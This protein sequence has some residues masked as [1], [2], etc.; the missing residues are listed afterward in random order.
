MRVVREITLE[1]WN[2]GRRTELKLRRG[3]GFGLVPE[4]VASGEAWAQIGAHVMV[5]QP[6][7]ISAVDRHRGVQQ[8]SSSQRT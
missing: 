5:P 8:K 1:L 7:K 3:Y 4:A 6:E 2:G